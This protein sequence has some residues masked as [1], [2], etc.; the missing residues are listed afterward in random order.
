MDKAVIYSYDTDLIVSHTCTVCA[1]KFR[2]FIFPNPRGIIPVPVQESC[3][4]ADLEPLR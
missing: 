3:L 1:L 4:K 2:E